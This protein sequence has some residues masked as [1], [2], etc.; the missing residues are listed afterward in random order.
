MSYIEETLIRDERLLYRTK[1]H[2][3]IFTPAIGWF[4][5]AICIFI[6]A[7]QYPFANSPLYGSYSL[8][9][10]LGIFVLIVSAI[11]G[12]MAYVVYQTSEYGITN[13]RI[14]MKVGFISRMS[15]EILLQRVESIHV[16]QSIIGRFFDYG[17]I[18]VSGTGG[19]KDPFPNIPHPLL[20]RRYAQRQIE[21]ADEE[22]K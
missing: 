2:W 16:Y 15:L 17:T 8:T 7:P 20:F 11:S 10:L 9:D 19:S 4:F 21:Q 3:I 18:I 14:L 1:P 6:F 12:T 5:L 13:R 22:F